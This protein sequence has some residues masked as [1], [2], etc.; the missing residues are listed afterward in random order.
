MPVGTI[1]IVR[2]RVRRNGTSGVETGGRWAAAPPPPNFECV[3][4]GGQGRS[5][6]EGHGGHGP[7]LSDPVYTR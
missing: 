4:G 5:Q 6:G 1:P 7:S 2:K 3:C